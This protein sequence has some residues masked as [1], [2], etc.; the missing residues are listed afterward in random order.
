[1]IRRLLRHLFVYEF[2]EQGADLVIVLPIIAIHIWNKR[3][4]RA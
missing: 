4:R 1:M 3:L 2:R